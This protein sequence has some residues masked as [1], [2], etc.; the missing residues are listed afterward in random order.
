LGGIWW[1]AKVVKVPK[2]VQRTGSKGKKLEASGF[3]KNTHWT[4]PTKSRSKTK[5]GEKKKIS[6]GRERNGKP[7]G[8]PFR[9]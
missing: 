4:K 8:G 3:L 2:T 9:K 6:P 7:P 5:G 1:G